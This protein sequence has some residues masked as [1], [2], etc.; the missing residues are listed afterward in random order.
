M[1][2]I[3]FNVLNLHTEG[4]QDAK[5]LVMNLSYVLLLI[6][7]QNRAV[8]LITH[9]CNNDIFHN[10]SKVPLLSWRRFKRTWDATFSVQ[11]PFHKLS[12]ALSTWNNSDMLHL[13]LARY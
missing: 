7:I 3:S 12:F 11:S 1:D 8:K 6:I 4:M 13:F 9:H 5:E 2:D 10:E